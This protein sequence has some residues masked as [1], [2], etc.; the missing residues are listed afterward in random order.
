MFWTGYRAH[1]HNLIND[2]VRLLKIHCEF[3]DL[4]TKCQVQAI[5]PHPRHFPRTSSREFPPKDS[6]PNKYN[7]FLF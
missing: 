1:W 4:N 5:S 7:T 3:E 2:L 6:S